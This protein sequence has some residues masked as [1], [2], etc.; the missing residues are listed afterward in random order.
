MARRTLLLVNPWI[1]DFAAYDFWVRP[2]GLLVL[3]SLLRESGC[4]VRL[5]DCLD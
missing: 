4:G 3:A 1:H 5:V 2:L